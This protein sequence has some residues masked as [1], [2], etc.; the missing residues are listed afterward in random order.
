MSHST[1]L[2]LRLEKELIDRAKSFADRRGKSVS[3][4]VA[5][6]FRLLGQ[7]DE[8]GAPELPPITRSLK[9]ALHGKTV[10]EADYR[11]YLEEKH[12]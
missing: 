12:L 1:K 3:R 11:R 4:M 10:D 9:G 6:Y 8:R 7:G 5:D 2:T